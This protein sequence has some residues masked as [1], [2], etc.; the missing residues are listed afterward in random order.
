MKY[1]L[2]Y[3]K[4]SVINEFPFNFNPIL[5]CNTYIIN[6]DDNE[7]KEEVLG[8]KNAKNIWLIK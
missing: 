7:N 6:I 1:C 8:L 5:K 4:I 3:L 2:I